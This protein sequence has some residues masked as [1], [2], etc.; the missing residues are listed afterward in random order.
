MRLD[1]LGCVRMCSEALVADKTQK[2][3]NEQNLK[4]TRIFTMFFRSDLKTELAVNSVP[5]DARRKKKR[6][7]MKCVSNESSGR[8]DQFYQKIVKIGAILGG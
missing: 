6:K 8:G 7:K 1:A 5:D 4:N 3:Y 2:K